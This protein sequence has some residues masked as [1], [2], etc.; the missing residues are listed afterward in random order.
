MNNSDVFKNWLV[1]LGKDWLCLNMKL[2]LQWL[3]TAKGFFFHPKKKTQITR[4]ETN[5]I[6]QQQCL[7]G[8]YIE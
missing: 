2:L 1:S 4:M 5:F 3:I 6:F 7:K 8:G